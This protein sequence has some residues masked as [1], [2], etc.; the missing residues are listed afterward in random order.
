[1]TA[2]VL[3]LLATVILIR[4]ER[5]PRYE[6]KP[7][8][9]WV[10]QLVHDN[11]RARQA[12]R[13]IGPASVPALADAVNRRKSRFRSLLESW[14]PRLPAFVARKLPNRALDQL[15]EERAIEVLYEFGPEAAPAVPALVGVEVSLNDV[16]GFGSSGL[17]HATLLRI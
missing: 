7:A 15:L 12:L 8:G 2:V 11:A 13:R 1:G 6:G 9:Y 17:A 3:L 14:R 10:E 4:I 16:I 5:G